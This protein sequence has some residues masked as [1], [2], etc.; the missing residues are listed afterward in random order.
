M[1]NENKHVLLLS[2]SRLYGS[3]YLDHAEDEI[4]NFLGKVKRV[5]FLPFAIHDRNGYA[6]ATQKRFAEM[7]YE[8]TSIHTATNAVQA[9][10]ETDAIFIGG[11]NTF[12]LLKTLYDYD[13]LGPIRDR[14]AAGMPYMG[15]S[16]GSNVACPSIKTTN[17]MPIVQPPSFDALALVPFQINPHYLDPDP[18]S[19]HMGETREERIIQFLEENDTPVVGLRE[20]AILRIEN[21]QTILRGSAGARIFR[22]GLE[23]LEVPPGAQLELL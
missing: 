22:K 17:D 5:L 15:A 12:R 20:G 8:L 2:T 19:K 10:K 23:P 11:G 9:V 6:S 13:L 3:G 21:G 18:N 1:S 14:V 7:G 4:R 16:A